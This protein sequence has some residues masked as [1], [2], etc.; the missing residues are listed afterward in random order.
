[1]YECLT[2]R[3]ARSTVT[4]HTRNLPL[5]VAVGLTI[6]GK[7]CSKFLV[8]LVQNLGCS[9][10]YS[11]VLRTETAM[12]NAVSRQMHSSGGLYVP[13]DLVCGRFIFCAADNID[14]LED[15]PDG[16]STLHA[17]VMT[18]YQQC[19]EDD[20]SKTLHVTGPALDRSMKMLKLSIDEPRLHRGP[21]NLKPKQLALTEQAHHYSADNL[22]SFA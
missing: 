13:S 21:K 1:M 19:A 5:Q 15:T 8:D 18:C 9:I 17:T 12:A 20:H 3:Q 6:H 7:T 16:K 10:E 11:K 4:H 14:F 22:L 2:D